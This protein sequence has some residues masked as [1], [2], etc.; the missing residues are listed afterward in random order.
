MLTKEQAKEELEKLAREIAYHDNLYHA[1]DE[2]EISD[3]AYDALRKR[4]NE[5]EAQFPDLVRSDSPSAKVG[6]KPNEA[7]GKVEHKVPML[8]L[9]NSF[10]RDDLEDFLQR[11]RNFL[12]LGDGEDIEVFAEPKID[13]LSF[14]ARFENG[15][16]V[17]AA[18]RGDGVT[19]EDITENIKHLVDFPLQINDK[20]QALEIRGEVYMSHEDFA[21]LN[22]DQA[23]KGGKIFAN[24]R[25]AAAG[26]LRQL[27][28]SI[29]ASRH[30]RYFTYGVGE[31]DLESSNLGQTQSNIQDRFTKLGFCTNKL[32]QKLENI[33]EIM[34]YYESLYDKRAGLSYDIDGIVYKVNDLSWQKRLG[35][36]ARSPRWA[37]AQ[38]FPAEQGKTI[39]EKIT[40]QV[41]RTGTLTPV[42]ILKPVNI[43]GVVVSRATLHN[44]DEIKR[45]DIREGDMVTIQ[46]A[47]DVIPQIVSSDKDKRDQNSPAPEFIFPDKCPVCGSI[48]KREEGEVAIKCTGGLVCEAQA[49][50]R[51]KH[52][53]S[54]N[55]FDIE[56]LGKKQVEEF[57]ESQIIRTPADIFTLEKRDKESLNSISNRPGWGKKSADNLFAAI[58]ERRNISFDRFIYSLGIPFIGASNAKLLAL[59]YTSYA[60]W[61][62]A[63]LDLANDEDLSESSQANE[64]MA[65]DGIGFK[66]VETLRNFFTEEHNINL[67]AELA[68]HLN[69]EDAVAVKSDSPIAGKIVVFTGT[70]TKMSRAEAKSNAES[71]GAKVS[72]SISS[73]TDYLIAGEAA[74]SKLKKAKDLGVKTLTEDQWLEL[75]D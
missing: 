65:I 58:N 47:G 73:K 5:L 18:T 59:N 54:R 34:Q 13:G 41:G 1:N 17:Q 30:L 23:A 6:A 15:V 69:I 8:S 70:L 28:S 67:L 20:S 19:G 48:A 57:W 75:I 14:S 9:A 36:V 62:Q 31:V 16:F 10:S 46:R 29:T 27:D 50:E 60:N 35:H 53:V 39:L 71:K 26:S 3:S 51:L 40:I 12:R 24:P 64:L 25:N 2:P 38:K 45:K 43:G 55:G 37:V 66:A 7:F 63:M 68:D 42:A 52:F 33:N 74:G 72:G 49:V 32:S 4:N 21:K 56:G 11:V 22:E 61:H 44:E